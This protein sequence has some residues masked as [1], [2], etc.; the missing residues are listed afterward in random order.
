M[1]LP[2]ERTMSENERV[3]K[4]IALFKEGFSCSQAVLA[5]YSKQFELEQETAM[6]LSAG[7][8]GGM[9]MAGTCGALTGGLMVI[10]LKHGHINAEDKEG[11]KRLGALIKDF[12]ARFKARTSAL[13]CKDL[14]NCDISTEEGLRHANETDLFSVVCPK[15]V[16]AAAEIL[17][18]MLF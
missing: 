2:L 14:M 5:A 10:G 1:N 15:A 7:F 16:R 8:G 17:E 9:K 4:A 13:N 6:K 18:E 11:K 12:T 3:E